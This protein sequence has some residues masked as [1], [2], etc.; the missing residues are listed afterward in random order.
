MELFDQVSLEIIQARDLFSKRKRLSELSSACLNDG[1]L[2]E[3]F[4]KLP[5]FRTYLLKELQKCHVK[6][7]PESS[8]NRN[9]QLLKYALSLL[10]VLHSMLFNSETVPSRQLLLGAGTVL[11]PELAVILTTDYNVES[12]NSKPREKENSNCCDDESQTV[13][14]NSESEDD[15]DDELLFPNEDALLVKIRELQVS[16]LL[17][18]EGII[19]LGIISGTAG[20]LVSNSLGRILG[21]TGHQYLHKWLPRTFKNFVKTIEHWR[22]SS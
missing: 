13:N 6:L 11:F 8:K 10:N 15:F 19:N 14:V 21:K 17:E 7:K 16:T 3:C 22:V 12:R 2:K 4:F 20:T 9:T 5:R 18:L 1:D